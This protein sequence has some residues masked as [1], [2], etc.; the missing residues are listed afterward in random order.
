MGAYVHMGKNQPD[1]KLRFPAKA[2]TASV[3][4]TVK[5]SLDA[6]LS[7]MAAA[8]TASL[9]MTGSGLTNVCTISTS[10]AA[11]HVDRSATTPT[12]HKR[13]ARPPCDDDAGV[14]TE[15]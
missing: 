13:I 1:T 3:P 6:V 11:A 14:R 2:A 15:A 4:A 9:W 12:V 7:S 8:E 10:D 5:N